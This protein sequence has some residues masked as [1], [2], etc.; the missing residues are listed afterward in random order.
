MMSPSCYS[1]IAAM[2]R[3][4]DSEVPESFDLINAAV[5]M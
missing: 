5:I 2:A 4:R 3:T 1:D